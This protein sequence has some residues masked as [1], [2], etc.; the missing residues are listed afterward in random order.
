VRLD[1]IPLAMLNRN[2]EP[3]SLA[4]KLAPAG[5]LWMKWRGF[6]D[7]LAKDTD[8]L[9]RCRVEPA[10]CTDGANSLVALVDE[11]RTLAG[12]RKLGIVNRAINLAI[13]YTNDNRQYGVNDQWSNPVMT[14]ERGRGDC[15][16]YAI[17]KFF[18]LREAGIS[19][20][21]L[22][23]LLGRVRADGSA[24]AVVA[25]RNEGR[26]LILDNRRM[27]LVDSDFVRDLV[28]LFAFDTT[29][30]K[31]FDLTQVATAGLRRDLRLVS[32]DDEPASG[33]L[34]LSLQ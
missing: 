8:M 7:G 4:S 32:N 17:A 9:T 23:M 18:V 21:D 13:A 12:R 16:D 19:P 24:H 29:G 2:A 27:A 34:R 22:R 26:W 6:D 20:Q 11:A 25:V 15:E 1:A 31:Q 30:V 10:S 14:F 33:N 3:F 28:P 5:P